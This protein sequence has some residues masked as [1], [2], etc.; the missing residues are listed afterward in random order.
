MEV[1]LYHYWR[2]SCSWR[3]R[4]ALALKGIAY[5]SVP[6]NLL[7]QEQ[8]T[9][10]YLAINP[11]GLVPALVANGQVLCE[12]LAII[13]WLEQIAPSPALLPRD[14]WERA[15]VR[16]LTLMIASGIQPIQNLR[17]LHEHSSDPKERERWARHFIQTGLE[18][19]EKKLAAQSGP[20]AFGAEV[21]L[22]DLFLIPQVYNAL[23][24]QVD[25]SHLPRCQSIYEQATKTAACESAAPHNQAGATAS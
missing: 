1:T 13:E 17:V 16:E 3:V 14:P 7:Q 10:D 19:V 9:P 6:I 24:F 23:R 15:R 21:G 25:M 18:G 12:S 11:S 4:W 20:F 22:A 8:K 5:R 2:S